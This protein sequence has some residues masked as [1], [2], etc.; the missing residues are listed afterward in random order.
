[1]KFEL[2]LVWVVKYSDLFCKQLLSVL[3]V[4]LT[5]TTIFF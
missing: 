5:V 2:V 1:M 3:K 4:K